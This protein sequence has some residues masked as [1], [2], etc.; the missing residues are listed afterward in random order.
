MLIWAGPAQV[1]FYGGIAAGLAM[2]AIAVADLVLVD[3]L[4][5]DDDGHPADDRRQPGHG[6]PLQILAAHYM[7]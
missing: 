6:L 7:P 4:L 2:P 3:P 5:A 1:L